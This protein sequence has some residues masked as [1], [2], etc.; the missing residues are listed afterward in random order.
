MPNP[1]IFLP[2]A[3]P[4]LAAGHF[5]GHRPERPGLKRNRRCLLKMPHRYSEKLEIEKR[6]NSRLR[7]ATRMILACGYGDNC[8]V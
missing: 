7:R 4:H 8:D 3:M 5:D 6:Y 1:H 2:N